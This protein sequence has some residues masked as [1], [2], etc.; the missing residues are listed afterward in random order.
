MKVIGQRQRFGSHL[1][2]DRIRLLCH[3]LGNPQEHLQFIHVA[4]T[5]GKGSVSVLLGKVLEESGYRVG[6]FTSPHLEHYSERFQINGV[7]VDETALE[8]LVAQ[9]E[10]ACLRVE[11]EYPELGPVTEFELATAVGFLYFCESQVDMVVLETGLGGRLDATNVVVPIISVIT[12]IGHDHTDRLGSSLEEIA[13]EKG[14]IIKSGVPVISGVEPGL[15]EA[16]LKGIA[17]EQEAPWRSTHDLPW[18]SLAWNLSGGNLSFPGWGQVK[19]GL[20]GEHQIQNAATALLALQEL[21]KLGWVLP[22][23]AVQRGMAEVKWPGRLEVLSREPFVIL[24]G[25]HNQ[26]GMAALVRSLRH[27]QPELGGEDFTFVFGMLGN[28][29]LQLLDPLFPLAKRFVFTAANSGRLPPMDPRLLASYAQGHGVDAVAYGDIGHALQ[30][31]YRT[32]P[33]CICGSLYLA[34]AVK[35]FGR[36]KG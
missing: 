1:G 6:L 21:A 2:L 17:K 16:V 29:S 27:L 25:G 36:L 31:A 26:E 15:A 3:I 24:D 7:P 13:R 19:V 12:T 9:G 30:D 10:A 32:A 20:L 11:A 34:G 5:N 8:R 33:I 28:K 22:L 14:G 23:D 4:G 35:R 18:K